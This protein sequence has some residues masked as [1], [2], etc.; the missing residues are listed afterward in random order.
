MSKMWYQ[1]IGFL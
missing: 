1:V